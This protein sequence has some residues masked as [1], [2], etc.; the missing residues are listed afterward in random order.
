MTMRDNLLDL[1]APHRDERLYRVI[2]EKGFREFPERDQNYKKFQ[3]A[4]R[5]EIL[6]YLPIQLDIEHVSR[7]NYRCAMCQ[8]S[9]WEDSKR[10]KDMAFGDF[11]ALLD[12]QIGLVEVK[13][14]G[15]G[16]PLLSKDFFRMIRYAR[17][18]HLWVRSTTNASLLHHNDNYKKVLDADI[19]ELQVSIDGT[20]EKSYEKI[21]RG[22]KFN[23]VRDNCRL[24]N[25]Y[26]DAIGR[27]R[28]RMWS[29]IQRENYH[30][31]EQFPAMAADWGF[32]RITLSLN[33]NSWAQ[34]EWA[35]ENRSRD[36]SDR[37]TRKQAGK[38]IK[39]GKAAGVEVTF[40]ITS[41]KYE[42]AVPE[43]LCPMPFQRLYISSDMRI[44]PCAGVGDPRTYELGNAGLLSEE[45]NGEAMRR[46]RR[47]HLQGKLLDFCRAC[48]DG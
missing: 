27:K 13:I 39:L 23:L 41:R 32:D 3:S 42:Q 40:W 22:G 33:L 1:P 20:S 46:F 6:D 9:D 38:L 21:R 10:A 47:F 36:V 37:L 24:L 43:K 26:G 11:K 7:C 19:S 48:Y 44:V 17:S 16:E 5:A 12:S 14:Q 18:R 4:H 45:W 25:S 35:E 28:T 8:V 34:S 29:L 15:M 30:E 31:L 2:L